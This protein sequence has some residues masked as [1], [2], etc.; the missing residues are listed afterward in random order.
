MAADAEAPRF[1]KGD[2]AEV[3]E[4]P[5]NGCWTDAMRESYADR[6]ERRLATHIENWAEIKAR[7]PGLLAS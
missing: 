2:A 3:I 4:A 7:A 6:I 1:V 5:A